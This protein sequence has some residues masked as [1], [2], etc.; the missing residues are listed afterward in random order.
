MAGSAAAPAA[1]RRKFRRGSFILHLPLASHHSITSSAVASSVGGTS[2]PSALAVCRLMM[3]SNLLVCMTGS[4][5]G[6]CG[7][8]PTS[9]KSL[10]GWCREAPLY[11]SYLAFE[12]SPAQAITN[13]GKPTLERALLFRITLGC[14]H[15]LA[16]STE[17]D[18]H[19]SHVR[20]R[21]TCEYVAFPG[22]KHDNHTDARV[23]VPI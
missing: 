17:I 19:K 13:C 3:N 15:L 21:I 22:G 16:E 6:F 18:A 9:Q 5:A 2:M 20:S 12:T 8:T 7:P 10:A 1:R 14:K 4:S 11:L 23:G